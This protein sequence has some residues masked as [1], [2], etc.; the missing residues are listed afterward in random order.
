MRKG[1]DTIKTPLSPPNS[2]YMRSD[3][4]FLRTATPINSFLLKVFSV[5]RSRIT[6][7]RSGINEPKQSK[8]SFV[9][10]CER[11]TPFNNG[12]NEVIV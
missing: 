1:N 10:V 8:I 3:W 2:L 4:I 12:G 9:S 5:N 6:P 7:E 11:V